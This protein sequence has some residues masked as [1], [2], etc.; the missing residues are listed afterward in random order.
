MTGRRAFLA[1][2]LA[3]LAAAA[4]VYG[5][6][7]GAPPLYD[8]QVYLQANPFNSLPA[9]DV[10]GALASRSYFERT[11]ERSWQPLVSA[12]EWAA[13]GS[14]APVRAVSLLAL[15]A[16]GLL[17]FLLG[18]RL[19][20]AEREAALAGLLLV[21]FPAGT[22][23]VAVASFAGH[24]LALAAVCGVL[25]AFDRAL[26]GSAAASWAAAAALAGGLLSK[27]AA[28]VA[29]PAAAALA[30]ARGRTAR[31]AFRAAV[32]LL[33]AA[34]LYLSWRFGAL[35]PPAPLNGTE[36]P[37]SWTLP[38][39]AFGAHLRLLAAPVP[40]CLERVFAPGPERWVR[41]LLP[42]GW[43][44][45]LWTWRA[46]R[47]RVFLLLWLACAAAPTLHFL[48]FANLSPAA[49]RYTVAL[50]APAVLALAAA[51]R[52]RRSVLLAA[53]CLCWGV[54]G[55]LR[56][57]TMRQP[58]ALAEQTVV[59]APG[60]PRAL[61]ILASRRLARGDVAGASELFSRVFSAD[62]LFVTSF[63]EGGL[64]H[65]QGRAFVEGLLKLQSGD[66]AAA[67]PLFEEAA[68]AAREPHARA[69][70]LTRLGEALGLVGRASE[71]WPAFDEASNLA[72]DWALP[73][74]F[75]GLILLAQG[76][77]EDAAQAM[78]QADLR[79][80]F[81]DPPLRSGILSGRA[82]S[83]EASGRWA[84]AAK[85]WETAA[86]TDRMPGPWLAAG[87]AWNLAGRRAEAVRAYGRA[88]EA[89]RSALARL[90]GLGPAAEPMRAAMEE[91]LGKARRA[92]APVPGK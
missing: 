83:Y 23:A 35:L 17:V 75:R 45:A 86:G 70:A 64:W 44:A 92:G 5:P 3:L 72:P 57:G 74:Y 76:R 11:Q 50:A 47:P 68:A 21:V 65:S 81:D 22:E 1:A 85:D 14:P 9:A 15:V 52:T 8:D 13:A 36:Y 51:G 80:R 90:E 41:F 19:G 63:R 87:K 53:L 71:A 38:W 58:D 61:S 24:H 4:A 84:E 26:E 6:L 31:G 40:L 55:V 29:V 27:E 60:H 30:W 56:S 62:P 59:C 43:L 48:S 2:A 67:L 79:L 78:D 16:A 73:Y 49:D 28:L 54:I 10:L 37:G 12:V 88:E 18:L 20:L 69:A 66:S 91:A 34:L 33:G 42:L 82:L 7:L 77:A 25:L 32:P 46:D 89:A 39:E